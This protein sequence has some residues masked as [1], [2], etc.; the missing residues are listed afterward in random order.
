MILRAEERGLLKPGSVIIE[1]TSG[2]GIIWHGGAVP[3]YRMILTMPET[4][5]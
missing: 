2:N 3:V 1:P 5:V 4:M